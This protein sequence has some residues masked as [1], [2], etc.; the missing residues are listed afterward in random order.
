MLEPSSPSE[1][2]KFIKLAFEISEQFDTP[3][4]FRMTTRV[5]HTKENVEIGQRQEIENKPFEKNPQK[6]VMVPANAY[7]KHILLEE[8]LIKLQEYSEKT[9]LNKIE[10]NDK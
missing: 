2:K 6:Y 7:K 8:K 1:E 5:A 9:E 3:V 10:I 4:L